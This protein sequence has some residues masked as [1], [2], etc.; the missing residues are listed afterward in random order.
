M[1][2][3]SPSLLARSVLVCLAACSRPEPV[4]ALEPSATPTTE[5][6]PATEPP[7]QAAP[8]IPALQLLDDAQRMEALVPDSGQ[9][10]LEAADDQAF[11]GADIALVTPSMAKASGWLR[12]AGDGGATPEFPALRVEI[13]DK[14]RVWEVPVALTIARDDLAAAGSMPGFSVSFDAGALPAGRYHLYL[15]YRLGGALHA[16]D[17]GRYVSVM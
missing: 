6:T 2:M 17:N 11:G 9:C 5:P 10:N 12:A 13:E 7:P 4:T 16:C 3:R 1:S 14:S 15:T 8:S